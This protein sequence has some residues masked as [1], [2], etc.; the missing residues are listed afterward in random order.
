MLP[1]NLCID[2]QFQN[3]IKRMEHFFFLPDRHEENGFYINGLQKLLSAMNI[4]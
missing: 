2:M 4:V 1:W 3:S